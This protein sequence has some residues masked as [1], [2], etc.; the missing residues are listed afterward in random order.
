M[1]REIPKVHSKQTSDSAL[2]ALENRGVHIRD[3]SEIVLQLQLPYAKELTI[4]D[5][6]ESV[7]AVLK[8]REMHHAILVAIELDVLAEN[9]QLSEPLQSIVDSD[10]GLFGVDET[11]ALGA[12][13]THGSIAMTTFGYLDKSKIGIIKELDTNHEDGRV[14]TFLDDIVCAIVANASSRIAHK[15]RDQKDDM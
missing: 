3:M 12:V 6:D 1:Q 4:E 2:H 14:N 5:C 11:I 10:E 15:I 9:K 7:I 8:K 13:Q